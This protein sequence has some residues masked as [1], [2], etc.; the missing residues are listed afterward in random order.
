VCAVFC[1]NL[2][3]HEHADH[4]AKLSWL[5]RQWKHRQS[6]ETTRIGLRDLSR[7]RALSVTVHYRRPSVC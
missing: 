6:T 3:V 2:L 7:G 5:T 4:W 1:Y